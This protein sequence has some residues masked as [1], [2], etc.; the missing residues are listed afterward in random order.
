MTTDTIEQPA[1]TVATHPPTEAEIRAAI[2]ERVRYAMGNIWET[3]SNS[4]A[5]DPITDSDMALTRR[6]WADGFH[7]QAG[8]PGTLWADL[9]AEESE[10][11]NS[12]F[13]AAVDPAQL[14]KVIT[15]SVVAAALAFAERHPDIPRGAWPITAA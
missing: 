14:A 15:E 11:L 6:G 1:A 9:T 4:N 13:S 5:L 8:H 10:E 7:P 2:T 3:L 12:V